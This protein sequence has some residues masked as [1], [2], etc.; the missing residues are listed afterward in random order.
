MNWIQFFISKLVGHDINSK[1]NELEQSISALEKE[2]SY[3]EHLLDQ[4]QLNLRK[5]ERENSD[6]S[7]CVNELEAALTK[8]KE[9]NKTLSRKL[10]ASQSI[11]EEEKQR[12]AFVLK[13]IAVH[14][15]NLAEAEASKDELR[16]SHLKEIKRS[17]QILKE[18]QH[19]IS[20]LQEQIESILSE[21]NELVEQVK[22]LR[23]TLIQK[24]EDEKQ[25]FETVARL[26]QEKRELETHI[27]E[28]EQ[29]ILSSKEEKK[30]I[31]KELQEKNELLAKKDDQINQLSVSQSN[32]QEAQQRSSSSDEVLELEN[33]IQGLQEKLADCLRETDILR[34]QLEQKEND[35]KEIGNLLT[36][37]N[38]RIGE[39]QEKIADETS[40]IRN[41]E[42]EIQRLNEAI[43]TFQQPEDNI[44]D[45]PDDIA[46]LR[47]EEINNSS[48][49]ES[50]HVGVPDESSPILSAGGRL[51]ENDKEEEEEMPR[52]QI[53]KETETAI[54][55][56]K[57]ESEKT[58][59]KDYIVSPQKTKGEE[60]IE[61]SGNSIV[62][63]PQ[64]INDSR[65]KTNQ[66][67]EYVYNK[68]RERIISEEFFKESAEVIARKSRQLEEAFR[69]GKSDFVCGKCSCPVKIGH[70]MVNGIESLFFVH[71]INDVDCEWLPKST[72]SRKK[73][74]SN[75]NVSTI[76]DATESRESTPAHSDII[77]EAGN[78]ITT[79]PTKQEEAQNNYDTNVTNK[80]ESE[81]ETKPH[82]QA[83]KEK[84]YSLLCTPKSKELGISDVK[85]DTL[86]RSTLPYMKW[87]K[88]DISF[89]YKEHNIVIVMQS[90]KHDLRTLVDRD[91][92]F[93]LNNYQVI[94]IFG[95]D[96]DVTYG[97]MRK[98]N[99]KITLFDC[100]RNVFVFDKEAQQQSEERNTLCL[101][102][103]WLDEEDNWAV[104][105]SSMQCNGL[106]ADITD[107]IFDEKYGKPYIVE[108]NEPYFNLHPDV[109][110][111]FLETQK[112]K[113]QLLEEFEDIWKG[114]PSY[115]EALR[116]LKLRNEKVTPYPYMGLW[117]FRFNST[118]LI[119]PIFSEQP[120][121]LHNGFF[122]VK[123]GETA[124]LVNYYSEVVMDWTILKCDKLS[125]DATNN[126]V[127]FHDNGMW[128]VADLEG[129]VLI[130][131]QFDAINPWSNSLYR[132]R[133]SSKLWGLHNIEDQ[134]IVACIY[135]NIGNLVSGKAEANLRDKDKS[136][137]TYKGFLDA[138][139]NV[140]DSKTKI[141]N[142]KYTAFERF[143]KWGIRT[144]KDQIVIIP[145]YEDIQPW[146][147]EAAKV[148]S[149]GKWGVIGLPGGNIIIA[150]D[151]DF[152]GELE[153]GTANITYVGVTKIIDA[154]GNIL[155]EK[156][157]ELQNG[158]VK[159]KIGNKW[160][161]EKDGV[162]IVAHK[163]DEI[164]SFRR[165]L[166][167]VINSSIVKLNAYYDYPIRISGKCS[168]YT[169]DGIKVN[170]SGVYGYMSTSEIE[171][172]GMKGKIKTG[173]TIGN[174]AFAN[175]IFS[176]K[177][178]LL[179]FVSEAQMA[180]KTG[181]GDKDS[182][183]SMNEIV[184]GVI[185]RI[186]KHKTKGG[187]VKPTKAIL[188]T[189]DGRET[190]I[191]KRFFSAARLKIT[192]FT[193]GDHIQIQKTG[194]D[195]ELDQ[196]TWKIIDTPHTNLS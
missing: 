34:S 32:L 161:I 35:I 155:S 27:T 113:E 187:E 191:P 61:M 38:E 95:A 75:N 44:V 66:K 108:A 152:I 194:F 175:L 192:D 90:R 8:E 136:W 4:Q 2:N 176:Q 177:Q 48:Q 125:V 62:D 77:A 149:N 102:Y 68:K 196:T 117:G 122:M 133:T 98:F 127:L 185:K 60:V 134:M 70:R 179:K 21:K 49:E 94:W 46:D 138:K 65:T 154:E 28:K 88:P 109:K 17:E 73:H 57:K 106:I 31:L 87:R 116:V 40:L 139:G 181:H 25:S 137:I 23:A 150:L 147:E 11:I 124:G 5:S 103:N 78:S 3:L 74:P 159:T 182:D 162:E 135:D 86:I 16:I 82:G 26:T 173:H 114:E 13:R 84:I 112:T 110:A 55:P 24:T 189:A 50:V 97:Y 36:S 167:G 42:Q 190:M 63:F 1:Q 58:E 92:F 126:R 169:S 99:H 158:F 195:D 10:V 121:D 7:N 160:G 171:R 168:G 193:I 153:N 29:F 170:I 15:T 80:G 91:V 47:E 18:K 128:G 146:T 163:Y 45:Q 33:Q 184:T 12:V 157:I 130:Q 145:T 52:P 101:K 83:L 71:A 85:C 132:V 56:S 115:I 53:R 20:S 104:S 37:A 166:I 165:R 67:I 118:T 131:P 141:L 120:V 144:V 22:E 180:Q 93:R 142:D 14:Q 9:E 143:E 51:A 79:A 129:K 156:S 100:H 140:V 178:Y 64:I 76:T 172:S 107:F 59:I 89:K 69:A 183:F 72:S 164:G 174:M 30:S 186:I 81:E 188:S 6:L 19:E 43:F 148:K 41:Q 151:Y 54:F 96:N 39:Y 105:L 119:Q 123:L 111:L